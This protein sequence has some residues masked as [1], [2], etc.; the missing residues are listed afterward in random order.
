MISLLAGYACG[1]MFHVS[2]LNSL[3]STAF[4]SPDTLLLVQ[5][6]VTGG[7]DEDASHLFDV[8]VAPASPGSGRTSFA[9]NGYTSPN[10][11]N[12]LTPI[13]SR[14]NSVTS[15]SE[16]VREAQEKARVRWKNAYRVRQFRIASGPLA[17]CLRASDSNWDTRRSS[18]SRYTPRGPSVGSNSSGGSSGGCGGTTN[19]LSTTTFKE[20]FLAGLRQFGMICIGLYRKIDLTDSNVRSKR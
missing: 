17:A 18:E 10:G 4:Y 7:I 8:D 16:E 9:G 14:S 12:A 11:G 5:A 13:N 19:G 2:V 6:I 3:L 20:L 1:R 15:K